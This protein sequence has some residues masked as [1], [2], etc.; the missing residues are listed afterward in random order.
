[1][2]IKIVFQGVLPAI[3][4]FKHADKV[5]HAIYGAI[6]SFFSA[7]LALAFDLPPY[8]IALA[9]TCIFAV[10][11]EIYDAKVRKVQWDKWDILATIAVPL[12]ALMLR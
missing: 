8:T 7:A 3:S 12:V 10:S 1:M 9:V 11:K 6:I 4:G 5:T 2:D